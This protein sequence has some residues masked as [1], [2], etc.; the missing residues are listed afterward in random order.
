MAYSLWLLAYLVNIS[1]DTVPLKFPL[2]K[3]K[4]TVSVHNVHDPV[5]RG[6]EHVRLE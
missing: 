5:K 6:M 2:F 3:L 4:S 1:G